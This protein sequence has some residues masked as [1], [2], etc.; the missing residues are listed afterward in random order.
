M[1]EESCSVRLPDKEII[2]QY[3]NKYYAWSELK[4]NDLMTH[5][6][7]PESH[8]V[9]VY[10]RY[11]N[12][13]TFLQTKNKKCL[14]WFCLGPDLQ[15]KKTIVNYFDKTII[16]ILFVPIV[17]YEHTVLFI[18]N[19]TTCEYIY[20][21]LMDTNHDEDYKTMFLKILEKFDTNKT[22]WTP[23]TDIKE[24]L[25]IQTKEKI[26]IPKQNPGTFYCMIM[27]CQYINYLTSGC[28]GFADNYFNEPENMNCERKHMTLQFMEK[29]LDLTNDTENLDFMIEYKSGE[30]QQRVVCDIKQAA[31]PQSLN[32]TKD[33]YNAFFKPDFELKKED[34]LNNYFAV[35]N[36]QMFKTLGYTAKPLKY[37][38]V[39]TCFANFPKHNTSY[40]DKEYISNT[41]IPVYEKCGLY[42]VDNI[43]ET[44]YY[45][46]KEKKK[47]WEELP[48]IYEF[49]PD[50]Y[51]PKSTLIDICYHVACLTSVYNQDKQDFK[52][53]MANQLINSEFNGTIELKNSKWQQKKNKVSTEDEND[54]DAVSII[55]GFN[56]SESEK[57]P[58]A[59]TDS[60]EENKSVL[61][62][63]NNAELSPYKHIDVK[64]RCFFNPYK[65]CGSS[66]R[67][68]LGYSRNALEK[69]ALG[70]GFDRQIVHMLSMDTL[71]KVL[72]ERYF[73][74]LT[75][76]YL[77]DF[78][79]GKNKLPGYT[80][81]WI[82]LKQQ[83][84]EFLVNPSS[85]NLLLPIP[86]ELFNTQ[87]GLTI[88]T[89]SSFLNN[90]QAMKNYHVTLNRINK[91][92]LKEKILEK[93][94]INTLIMS[95][96]N[97]ARYNNTP[98][99][100]SKIKKLAIEFRNRVVRNILHRKAQFPPF[101]LVDF[102]YGFISLRF[103]ITSYIKLP[104][105]NFKMASII[106]PSLQKKWVQS[107]MYFVKK[108]K[109]RLGEPTH[110][111]EAIN[112]TLELLPSVN[113]TKKQKTIF[114]NL[115]LIVTYLKLNIK[116]LDN[117]K[118][119]YFESPNTYFNR[120][121][122]IDVI[123]FTG[124][125]HA[126]HINQ[127]DELTQ[128]ANNDISRF[129]YSTCKITYTKSD[130][131][132][133]KIGFTDNKNN[134][135][136][137][138][139]SL[140]CEI[141]DLCKTFK[142]LYKALTTKIISGCNV[143]IPLNKKGKINFSKKKSNKNQEPVPRFILT[144][145]LLYF[146]IKIEN[147]NKKTHQWTSHGKLEKTVLEIV[148][149]NLLQLAKIGKDSK[150]PKT[151]K[152]LISIREK[153]N[154]NRRELAETQPST[155]EVL[156]IPETKFYE[157]LL[158]LPM[159]KDPSDTHADILNT[160]FFIMPRT[161]KI[162]YEPKVTGYGIKT[163]TQIEKNMRIGTYY[164]FK[165]NNS[166][167][168][169]EYDNYTMQLLES[170]KLFSSKFPHPCFWSRFINEARADHE[171]ANVEFEHHGSWPDVNTLK[172]LK[173]N[174]IL[175]INYR[176]DNEMFETHE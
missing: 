125:D 172:N 131:E 159:F 154:S 66:V 118:V 49:K 11:I 24:I 150:K 161:V 15:F 135:T 160:V 116:N 132:W 136:W 106:F 5:K 31:S 21:G 38:C 73:Q 107:S 165:V 46:G 94:Q 72:R 120:F 127:N 43:R 26:Q 56:S 4:V 51:Q 87:Y 64:T 60:L 151:F 62:D 74:E 126:S 89:A 18:C 88:H 77:E 6:K 34:T 169:T 155:F 50:K 122:E 176:L 82:D 65:S 114:D 134:T 153:V 42:I 79:T 162:Y 52:K 157:Q 175:L 133:N 124:D 83:K 78:F 101:F 109:E 36:N 130:Q 71:C 54:D 44:Y 53:C 95:P 8:V 47:A 146:L 145:L 173:E 14:K 147:N 2:Y 121:A 84:D 96:P 67:T 170:G 104:T 142:K 113:L 25:N 81:S 144:N 16:K 148:N 168:E 80:K 59:I 167:Q 102:Y 33:E 156:T 99:L 37:Y 163:T 139:L 55:D 58:G 128:E 30:W 119:L 140:D 117:P 27:V 17:W 48:V 164:G 85:V 35:I 57:L 138:E 20:L 23:K 98:P 152:A 100:D 90:T 105:V 110:L 141:K 13:R 45:V 143:I 75:P 86:K 1:N 69:A 93:L 3:L 103:H 70:C 108:E 29:Q 22:K 9:T 7:M 28:T 97:F 10:A 12:S 61:L 166:E 91:L 129:D 123:D 112:H 32:I 19:N 158:Q 149:L 115:R 63:S 171:V 41:I 40:F 174:T 39:N 76:T 111:I 92:K 68:G 137:I